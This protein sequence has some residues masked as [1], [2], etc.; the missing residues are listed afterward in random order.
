MDLYKI[1]YDFRS[2]EAD[3]ITVCKGQPFTL[4]ATFSPIE[5]IQ[6]KEICPEFSGNMENCLLTIKYKDGREEKIP[7]NETIYDFMDDGLPMTWII[8]GIDEDCDLI[9]K[10]INDTYNFPFVFGKI[11]CIDGSII[12]DGYG[13]D[14]SVFGSD[15]NNIILGKETYK[16]DEVIDNVGIGNLVKFENSIRSVAIGHNAFCLGLDTVAIGTNADVE[17]DNSIAI[18]TDSESYVDNGIAIGVNAKVKIDNSIQLGEG[19]LSSNNVLM[20]VKEFPLLDENGGIFGDRL[21]DSYVFE[22][23]GGF[24]S[25]CVVR[26]IERNPNNITTALADTFESTENGL[27]GVPI[28]DKATGALWYLQINNGEINLKKLF[29]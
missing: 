8:G 1:S 10:P 15:G 24:F 27:L 3:A 25:D 12:K 17:A 6:D 13:V 26:S 21:K 11:R 18:G 29:D 22:T 7:S 19:T 4:S 28:T 14:K 23:D 2:P 5:F 20:Q 16:I 9:V